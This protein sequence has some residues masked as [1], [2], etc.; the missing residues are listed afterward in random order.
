MGSFVTKVTCDTVDEWDRLLEV[1]SSHPAGSWW[2]GWASAKV[3]PRFDSKL[4][5]EIY[6]KEVVLQDLI[7]EHGAVEL[8]DDYYRVVC[9]FLKQDMWRNSGIHAH[10][11]FEF[12]EASAFFRKKMKWLIGQL[13]K[14]ETLIVSGRLPETTRACDRV[15]LAWV[16]KNDPQPN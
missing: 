8:S 1:V 10:P 6:A 3:P 5:P 9:A 14:N 4:V 13:V 11:G 15:E 2:S 12:G 16:L 7:Q